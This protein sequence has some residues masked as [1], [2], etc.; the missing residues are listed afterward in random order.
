VKFVERQLFADPNAAEQDR[1]DRRRSGAGFIER[2][3]EPF[4]AAVASSSA[5]VSSATS[6]SAGCGGTGAARI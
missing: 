5:P 6:L 2:V 1:R 4:L 3:N